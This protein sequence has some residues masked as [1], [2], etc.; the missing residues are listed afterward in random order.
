M[1]KLLQGLNEDYRRYF[2]ELRR[3]L[4]RI[5][6]VAVAARKVGVDPK[7][8]PEIRIAE[9]LAGLVEGFIGIR[10]LAE[11]I[12]KLSKKMPR[13]RMAFKIAEEIV[14]GR[15]GR[16]GEE[17]AAAQAIRTALA[18]LTEGVTAAVYSEGIAKVL[19]KKNMDGSRYLAIYFAGPIRSAGGT[20]TALTPVVA[21]LVRRLL[22]LDRYKPTEEEINRFIEELRLYER[23]VS[24]FQYRVSDEEL[25]KALRHLP[26]EITGIPS[27]KIEVSSHRNLPR[28]ETNCLRGGALRV[29]NDG[30][31][32][33]A[34]KVLAVVEEL[35]IE[36]WEWLKEIRETARKKRSSF[37]EDV[38]AGRPI[39]SFPSM[40][41]GFRLRYGRSRNTGLSAVAVHPLTMRTL[42]DFL[43]GGTQLKIETPGKSGV[44][45][46]V[47][48][49]E[50][51]IVRLKDGSVVRVTP[52]NFD[53]I[54]DEIDKILFLGDLLVSFGDFLY[55]NKKLLPAG[56][57]EE[58]WAEEVKEAIDKRFKGDLKE[59]AA[60]VSV[61]PNSMKGYIQSPLINVPPVRDAIRIS[62]GLDVPLH[63]AYTYFWAYIDPEE[64]RELRSWL[65]ESKIEG[66]DDIVASIK[67]KLS[68][69]IK[70]LLERICIPHRV[71]GDEILIEDDDAYVFS[72]SLGL[73]RHER[74]EINHELST[75]EN[76]AEISGIKIRDKAPTFIG[77]RVGRPEKASRREMTP[78]VHVLF[79][80]GLNGGAQR[81]LMKASRERVITVEIVKRRCPSCR[82]ATFMQ[83]CPNCK[84]PT[85]IESVCPRCGRNIELDTCPVC[86]SETRNYERQQ[87]PLRS[88]IDE[89]CGKIGFKPKQVKGVKG[90]T[91]RTKTPEALEKGI[92]RAKY[93]LSVYKDGTVRFD[94][95]N[96]PLT[97]FKPS[98]IGVSVERLRE[99]GYR[100]DYEGRP[101]T[102][103]N[104]LCELKIQDIVIPRKSIDYLIRITRFIDELLQ[105]VYHLPPYYNVTRPEDLVGKLV[106]GLAPHT[107]AGVL[108]RII[109][110]TDLN[111]C[112]AHPFWHSAKRRDCDGD[113]DSIMIALDAFL[114]FSRE[115]LPDRIGGIMD[116]P[117]FIIRMINPEEVQRQAHEMDVASGYPLRFY[118]ETLRGTNAREIMG[119]IDIV[120]HRLGGRQLQGFGFT[121]PTHDINEAN[122]ESQYKRLRRMKDKLNAQL[123]L[124]ERIE[125]VDAK[126]VAEIVLTTHFFRDISG[127][128]RAYTSQSFRCKRCNRRYRRAPLRGRCIECGGDLT[129]TVYRGGIEKYLE[130]ARKLIKRYDMSGY[131]AQRILLIEEE[132]ESIF[133]SGEGTRQTSLSRFMAAQG[134]RK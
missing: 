18:I 38:P 89:A 84:S 7:P 118:K 74:M 2:S 20:E 19:I 26:V 58:W 32:G 41:G 124:A 119:L 105:K 69:S 8:H 56:Y 65:L 78:P 116:S 99:L 129:L 54:K 40:R 91:N 68:P 57:T 42:Q 35:G 126:R 71:V 30:I 37:M 3:L 23:E 61:S 80:V 17:E 100:H 104:Q 72:Y 108:G 66:H 22:G 47:D 11:R 73:H 63:P 50:P 109:G 102:S 76:L 95:T 36:G 117:L 77:A 120:K 98:E 13:E 92:L 96:A 82:T 28:I 52:Q 12:R 110:F 5:I 59:A 34:A 67:G 16:L 64:L 25:R 48:S 90:L 10:N 122:R 86:K 33:R 60:A 81:D 93:G 45:L 14:N 29:V 111:V 43:A 113:E 121:V 6:E 75:L 132:I 106:I 115:Y 125:A 62:L 46:S 87:V 9:D 130:E 127:N 27:N 53:L 51:P 123:H 55:N 4:E 101:L 107:C 112:F 21:D 128:L 133:E 83:T 1:I 103:P 24:R 134:R 131:Y 39:L 70:G 49:I 15:F 31:I 114:N 79:P 94:M 88:L 97:H 44:V 85:I